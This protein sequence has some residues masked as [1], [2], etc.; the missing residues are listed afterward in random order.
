MALIAQEKTK[1]IIKDS[2]FANIFTE[3]KEE[4]TIYMKENF[5]VYYTL[6]NSKIPYFAEVRIFSFIRTFNV[7]KNYLER[8][9]H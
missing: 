8:A 5:F 1:K 4:F 9:N 3:I 6:E 7:S 2:M